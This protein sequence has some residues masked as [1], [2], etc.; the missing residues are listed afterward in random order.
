MKPERMQKSN[1][2]EPRCV[3]YKLK[4]HSVCKVGRH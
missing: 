4:P 3:F 1:E 2:E